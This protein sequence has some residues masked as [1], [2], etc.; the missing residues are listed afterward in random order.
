MGEKVYRL[1]GE[2]EGHHL[3]R[4]RDNPDYFR[5]L[6]RDEN[7]QNPNIPEWEELDLDGLQRDNCIPYPYEKNKSK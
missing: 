6:T 7:N 2:E 5:G 1:V 3:L 4:S